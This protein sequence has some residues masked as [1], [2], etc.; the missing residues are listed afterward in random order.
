MR[1]AGISIITTALLATTGCSTLVGEK[2]HLCTEMARFAN[3]TQLG[4]ERS[5]ELRTDW[6]NF[7]KSCAH[8]GYEPGKVFCQWLMSNTSTEFAHINIGR[9]LAC[10]D[11]SANYAS[12]GRA[13]PS[14][15]TGK[16]E[17]YYAKHADENVRI[18][19]EYAA[20]I[21]GECPTLK[22]TAE[23]WELDE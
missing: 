15:L 3:A 21:E 10:L 13:S 16:V 5:V 6:S 7:S 1:A 20:G 11:P 8:D 12:T 18:E 4:T 23:R 19:I 14:Y 22:I 17:S 9:A 2:D